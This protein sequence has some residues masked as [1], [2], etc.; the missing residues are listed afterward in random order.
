MPFALLTSYQIAATRWAASLSSFRLP[1][2][3]APASVSVADAEEEALASLQA[4]AFVAVRAPRVQALAASGLAGLVSAPGGYFPDG[5][6]RVAALGDSVV[7]P[8]DGYSARAV[9]PDDLSPDERFPDDC[10]AAAAAAVVGAGGSAA[11]PVDYSVK[12]ERL[13][14]GYPDV[15]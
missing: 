3:S 8:A 9:P 1:A 10:S 11:L 13:A 15:R 14:A 6:S 5:C 4:E 12:P 2:F 7:P